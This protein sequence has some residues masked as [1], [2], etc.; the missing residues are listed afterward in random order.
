MSSK[1]PPTLARKKVKSFSK[2]A[3]AELTE[4]ADQGCQIILDTIDQNGEIYTKIAT[5]LP[6]YT[7]MF[8]MAIKYTKLFHFKAHKKLP[9]WDFWIENIPSGNPAADSSSGQTLS[10]DS[11]G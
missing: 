6:K 1:F 11:S 4:A 3:T 9:N 2:Q 5:K 7:N 10:L 8:Q